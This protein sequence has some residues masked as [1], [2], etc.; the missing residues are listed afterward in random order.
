MNNMLLSYVQSMLHTLAVGRAYCQ[1]DTSSQKILVSMELNKIHGWINK[2]IYT[3]YDVTAMYT[4]PNMM[5]P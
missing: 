1:A 4:P 3:L 2:W 5:Y